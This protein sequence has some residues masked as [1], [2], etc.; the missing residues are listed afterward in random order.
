MT[1]ARVI[2]PSVAA[3][4][5]RLRILQ[6]AATSVGGDWFLD[7]VTGLARLGHTVHVVLPGPGPLADRLRAAGIASRSSRSR[8]G[9]VSQ[10]PR[11][12]A[13]ELRLR[14]WSGPSG[15]T[16]STLIC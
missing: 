6:V 4:P 16:S 7:Q 2:A 3:M 5:D 13:A 15:R 12:T 8:D 11:V 9:G 10:L 1:K 14:A